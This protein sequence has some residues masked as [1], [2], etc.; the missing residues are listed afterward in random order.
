MSQSATIDPDLL[1]A[2]V[3]IAEGRSFTE[4]AN[5]VGRTQSAVSMQIKRLEEILGRP[6]LHRGQGSSIELSRTASSCSAA[7]V[8][9]WH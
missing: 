4:A 6:V 1:R 9:S 2:F 8:K 5:L 3:L 7:P